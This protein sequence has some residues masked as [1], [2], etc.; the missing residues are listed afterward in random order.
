MPPL[1]PPIQDLISR[2]LTVSVADRI[3]ISQI[4]A[5]PA[6]R[7]GLSPTYILPKP[8]PLPQGIEPIDVKNV[9]SVLLRILTSIG[10]TSEDEINEELTSPDH[11]MA[12]IFY[13]MYNRIVSLDSIPWSGTDSFRQEET[14]DLFMMTPRPI[15]INQSN[16]DSFGRRRV[17]HESV[18]SMIQSYAHAAD[19]AS[20]NPIA[21]NEENEIIQ[22][23]FTDIQMSVEHLAEEMQNFLLDVYEYFYQSDTQFFIRRND[24]NLYI[25]LTIEPQAPGLVSILAVKVRGKGDDF[26]RFITELSQYITSILENQI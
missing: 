11:T 4:K 9:D 7:I 13:L 2:I 26:T 3:T 21:D 25:T 12:K 6:F 8:L 20:V 23:E 22:Q 15:A 18:E 24:S 10:Y 14:E 17:H 1:D 16:I 19:W 5:H